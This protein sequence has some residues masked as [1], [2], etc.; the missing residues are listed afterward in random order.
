MTRYG[1]GLVALSNPWAVLAAFIF[2]LPI[3]NAM[4]TGPLAAYMAELFPVRNRFTG[5]GISYQ[6][7]A[8]VAAG[9]APLVATTLV[10]A[11]AGSTALL[12]TLMSGLALVG[13]VAVLLSTRLRV[14]DEKS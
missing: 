10:G 2:L 4:V 8:T 7:A 11:L 13:I 3:G 5:V 9:F 12:T 14:V 6:L 1:R